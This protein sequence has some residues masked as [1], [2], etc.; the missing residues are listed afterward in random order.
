MKI[1]IP[2]LSYTITLKDAYRKDMDGH[3]CCER[4]SN[5]E[6]IIWMPKKVRKEVTTLAHEVTHALQFIAH[7]R[8]INMVL[9]QEHIAY[10]M[11]YI[12]AKI[13]NIKLHNYPSKKD[14]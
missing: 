11:Q 8:D 14:F 6:C 12:M 4:I 9:E 3:P 2:H 5:G 1:S 13:L 10:M 7:S